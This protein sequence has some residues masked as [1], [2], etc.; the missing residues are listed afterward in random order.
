MTGQEFGNLL[1]QLRKTS[2]M[3]MVD[4]CA[5]MRCMSD[6]IYRIENHNYSANIV[7]ILKYIGVLHKAMILTNGKTQYNIYELAD[8]AN[9]LNTARGDMSFYK[10]AKITGRTDGMLSGIARG[11]SSVGIDIAL[12][13]VDALGYTVKIEDYDGQKN[14]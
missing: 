13:L 3:K 14:C 4:I 2:G 11:K 1:S 7:K 10:L 8:F 6:K 9:W 5:D 12:S